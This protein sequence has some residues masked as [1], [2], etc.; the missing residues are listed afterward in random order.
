MKPKWM[1]IKKELSNKNKGI[2]KIKWNCERIANDII[3]SGFILRWASWIYFSK[4]GKS[5]E[6]VLF[7]KFLKKN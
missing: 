2:A 5:F 7:S 1:Q 6:I 4:F 3:P